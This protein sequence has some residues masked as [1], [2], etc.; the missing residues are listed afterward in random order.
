MA[1]QTMLE[2]YFDAWCEERP[3][4]RVSFSTYLRLRFFY[5]RGMLSSPKELIVWLV[6]QL[7]L[8][9]NP[10]RARLIS[11]C[12]DEHI[13]KSLREVVQSPRDIFAE[14]ASLIHGQRAKDYGDA[15]KSFNQIALL[16]TSYLKHPVT[17]EDVAMMMALLKM[18]RYKNSD[19]T[20]HDSIV[21]MLGYIALADEIGG[22]A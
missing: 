5:G 8:V 4:T 22:E 18:V 2:Y 10:I 14:A 21:D 7:A 9:Q 3:V 11:D 15:N 19:Y 1:I 12:L 6:R 13:Q 17:K 20:H 16:W